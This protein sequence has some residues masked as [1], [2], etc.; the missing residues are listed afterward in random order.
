MVGEKQITSDRQTAFLYFR[1][2]NIGSEELPVL[3]FGKF[4]EDGWLLETINIM[5][6]GRLELRASG[7]KWP[8]SVGPVE[9]S[10]IPEEWD[11]GYVRPCDREEFQTM[12]QL[13]IRYAGAEG[14]S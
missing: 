5:S 7:D 2:F 13:A 4:S 1:M 8:L 6:D 11:Y 3:Q 12:K 10:E 9:P 14:T